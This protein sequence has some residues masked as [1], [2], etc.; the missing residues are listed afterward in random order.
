MRWI[1]NS[2]QVSTTV[3]KKMEHSPPTDDSL[4]T[5]VVEAV[6][7]ARRH[8]LLRQGRCTEVGSRPVHRVTEKL[9]GV[10]HQCE[11]C[12]KAFSSGTALRRHQLVHSGHQPWSC[13]HCTARF[14]LKYNCRRHCRSKHPG[15][16]ALVLPSHTV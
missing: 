5:L 13:G 7:T 16:P 2:S 4:P 10:C 15:L 8:R 11:E 12:E 1:N 14:S 9:V 6:E 3:V